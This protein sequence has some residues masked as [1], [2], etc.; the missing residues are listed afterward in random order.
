VGGSYDSINDHGQHVGGTYA[1]VYPGADIS[2]Q[3]VDGTA[4]TVLGVLP[5]AVNNY[6]EIAGSLLVYNDSHAATYQNGQI[7]DLSSK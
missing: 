6:G 2:N 3:L 4:T 1:G 5:Y 7:K